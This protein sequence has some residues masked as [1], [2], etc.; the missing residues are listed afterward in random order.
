MRIAGSLIFVLAL[1]GCSGTAM[2]P[3]FNEACYGGDYSK[4]LSGA[5]PVYSATLSLDRRS[6]PI[7][8]DMLFKLAN[9][10]HLTAFDHGASYGQAFLSVY[11]CSSKGA[12]AIVDDRAAGPNAVRINVFAYNESWQPDPFVKDLQSA[13][14]SEWPDGLHEDDP[15]NTTLGNSLF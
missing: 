5:K 7:L 13:L 4:H 6:Q 1:L 10:H 2:P 3:G 9:T 11:L 15:K 8:R 14:A 12:F